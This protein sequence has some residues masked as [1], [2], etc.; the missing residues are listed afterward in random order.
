MDVAAKRTVGA[1]RPDFTADRSASAIAD[2]DAAGD[3]S[4]IRISQSAI[5]VAH[6]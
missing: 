1:A 2:R 4:P 6:A 3:S 5:A